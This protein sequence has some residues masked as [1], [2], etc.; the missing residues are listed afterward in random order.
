MK[1]NFYT[2]LHIRLDNGEPFY[3]GKGL[4]NKYRAYSTS[5]RTKY[6]WN[7][8]KKYG[9]DIIILE[10]NLTNEQSCEIEKYWI[11]RIGR[12]DLKLGTLVNLT[13]GGE[14]M[15]GYK[16]TE[17]H[18]NN[19]KKNHK[20]MSGKKHSETTKIKMKNSN[21]NSHFKRGNISWNSGKKGVQKGHNNKI[22]CDLIT[23]I[24]YDSLK[25]ACFYLNLNYK[26]VHKNLKYNKINKTNLIYA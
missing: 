17:N 24:F 10:D 7:I 26:G 18:K 16:M 19:L 3:V 23:G 2:Y 1:N 5:N 21:S 13:D 14:G 9:Y 22:V 20:G 11:K 6:W 4:K 8:V 12:R 25:E 15:D